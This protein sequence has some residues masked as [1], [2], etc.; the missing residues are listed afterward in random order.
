MTAKSRQ[1]TDHKK[2]DQRKIKGDF[3][4]LLWEKNKKTKYNLVNGYSKTRGNI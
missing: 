4:I 1:Q 2:I 3:C